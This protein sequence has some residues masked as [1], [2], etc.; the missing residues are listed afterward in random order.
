MKNMS[1]IL[2]I[3]LTSMLFLCLFGMPY[4]FYQLVRFVAMLG[5]GLLAYQAYKEERNTE[6]IIYC[7]LALL[8]Q[9]IFKIALGRTL[10]N[11]IDVIVGIG[12]L[13]SILNKPKEES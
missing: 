4:G 8:F 2:K 11:L 3:I 9:P 7:V 10:W 1:N 13:L 5:F 6:L 12:L